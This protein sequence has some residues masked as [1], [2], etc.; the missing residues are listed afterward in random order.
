MDIEA[1]LGGRERER[2]R[3]RERRFGEPGE[4]RAREV[5]LC[6]KRRRREDFL[7]YVDR[8]IRK[9]DDIFS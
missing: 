4:R 8:K 5:E 9:S 7:I 1:T 6:E 3:E 2:E